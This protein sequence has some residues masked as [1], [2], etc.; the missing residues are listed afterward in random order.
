M[1]LIYNARPCLIFLSFLH[2]YGHCQYWF[3]VYYQ[4]IV[5]LLCETKTIHIA[6]V[7]LEAS[8]HTWA[9]YILYTFYMKCV[10]KV[11]LS[12]KGAIEIITIIIIMIM[13][14]T[15]KQNWAE[16]SWVYIYSFFFFGSYAIFFCFTH[17]GE[18]NYA[19]GRQHELIYGCWWVLGKLRE[20]LLLLL[21]PKDADKTK[22]LSV[23]VG[24]YVGDCISVFQALL[25]GIS[26]TSKFAQLTTTTNNN[27]NSH[28]HI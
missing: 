22:D 1:T 20:L 12:L 3:F 28:T 19:E 14:S 18:G 27:N 23:L 16:E 15:C 7:I 9:I 13:H 10:S 8:N 26:S 11:T 4:Q 6:N 17:E 21:P 25:G 24:M 2:L 5:G